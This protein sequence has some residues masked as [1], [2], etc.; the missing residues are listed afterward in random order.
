[1]NRIASFAT[2]LLL[3]F[4]TSACQKKS[5]VSEAAKMEAAVAEMH[6]LDAIPSPVP[7]NSDP[8]ANPDTES[9]A[10]ILN[11]NGLLCAKVLDIR[12]LKVRPHVFEVTCIEYRGGRATKTYTLDLDKATAWAQ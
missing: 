2:V 5:D 12:P 7:A 4:A 11:L 1:M 9:V 8:L 10:T 6:R 3:V